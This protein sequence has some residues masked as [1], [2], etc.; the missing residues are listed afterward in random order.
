MNDDGLKAAEEKMRAAGQPEEAIRSFRHAYE[1]LRR[2]R[3][4]LVIRSAELE[5][6]GDVPTLEELPERDAAGGA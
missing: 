5:P 4:R 1:R 3:V 6:A 2:R